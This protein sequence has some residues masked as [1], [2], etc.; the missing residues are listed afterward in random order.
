MDLSAHGNVQQLCWASDVLITD[1]SSIMFDYA[2][3]DR[4]IVLYLDDFSEYRN[5]RGMYLDPHEHQ[6]G[7]IAHTQ[8]EVHDQ[9]R[10]L[11]GQSWAPPQE[12]EG[13]RQTFCPW[14]NG[15]AAESVIEHLVSGRPLPRQGPERPGR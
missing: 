10:L 6:P 2:L 12:L 5:A 8:A 1:Y 15:R 11:A 3:L 4:P 9:L 13:F 7:P 14:D